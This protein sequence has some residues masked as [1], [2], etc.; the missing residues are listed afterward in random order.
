MRVAITFRDQAEDER[1]G[2]EYC[3]SPLSRC[4]AKSLP[5]FIELESPALFNHNV[6]SASSRNCR[7]GF[8]AYVC[9]NRQGCPF[10]E[11]GAM[12]LL[13]ATR[14]RETF[15]RAMRIRHEHTKI[16]IAFSAVPFAA[17]EPKLND[18]VS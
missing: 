17:A 3:D 15:G 5:H 14:Q 16:S 11:K 9:R 12:P 18:T 4:K 1:R 7:A 2:N 10:D 13:Q 6:T 8:P